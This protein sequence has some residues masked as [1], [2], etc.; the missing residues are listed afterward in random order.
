MRT[1]RNRKTVAVAVMS[2]IAL[3]PMIVFA[4]IDNFCGILGLIQTI[5]N[6]FGT[7]VFIIAVIAILYS[8]FL[9]L[10]AGGNEE[11]LTTAKKVLIYGI[12]GIAVALLAVNAIKIIQATIGSTTGQFASCSVQPIVTPLITF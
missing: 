12:I 10:T 6:W 9:F 7:L 2:M 4:A 1:L 8:A 11:S 5:G 3:S